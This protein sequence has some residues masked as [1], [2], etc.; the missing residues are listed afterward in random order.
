MQYIIEILTNKVFMA[1]VWAWF[2][3]QLLKVAFELMF[4][5][6]LDFKRFVGAGGMPSSHSAFVMALTTVVGRIMGLGS[7]EFA[8]TL[9]ISIVVMYDAT[10]VR[11]AAGQQAKVLNMMVEN[12][13]NEDNVFFEKKL[14]ELIGHTPL[15]VIAGAV[16]GVIVGL[17][18]RL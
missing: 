18:V 7:T 15:E 8:I 5:K 10:G 3:A 12:W 1:A 11:R 6:K 4:A 2:I 14:K 9:A 17:I 16:L 13:H